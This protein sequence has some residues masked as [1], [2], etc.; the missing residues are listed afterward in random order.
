MH[1]GEDNV[2]RQRLALSPPESINKMDYKKIL[3]NQIITDCDEFE[4]D[5]KLG[6]Y[7]ENIP[8]M[9]EQHMRI[10]DKLDNYCHYDDP[11]P[12]DLAHQEMEN[13]YMLQLDK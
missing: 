12:M 1:S 3:A 6:L 9:I 11:D 7:K 4:E 2:I 10:V 8:A 13:E 5:I